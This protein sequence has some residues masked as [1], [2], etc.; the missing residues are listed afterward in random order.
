MPKNNDLKPKQFPM[1]IR[2]GEQPTTEF[3]N[4]LRAIKVSLVQ[5]PS[6]EDIKKYCI[7]F[8]NATWADN[9]F[10]VYNKMPE[11]KEDLFMHHIFSSK[12]LPTT[13][14][15]IRVNFLIEGISLQEVTH[16]LRYRRAVFSAECSGDKW[17]TH[18]PALV[19]TSIENTSP[20]YYR[21]KTLVEQ[22]KQLYVDMIDSRIIPFHDARTILPRCI[23]T[24]YYMS[25]SLKDALIFLFDRVDKQIQPMTDNVLAYR[26]LQELIA[27]YP[28][29]VKTLGVNFIEQPAKFY[30]QTARQ[31]RSTNFYKPDKDSDI[32]EWN[33]NDF[34]YGDRER[35][36][37]NGLD[38]E[39]D[40]FK[41]IFDETKS[42]II[43][44]N[45]TIDK[46]YG[47]DYFK[48]D[49]EDLPTF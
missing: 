36:E 14:E 48:Q 42:S 25:M 38:S 23:E 1:P 33:E 40:V 18:K 44:T 45:S 8:A 30:V 46:I 9:P 15:T 37:I 47:E 20:Y 16:I 24:Y 26:I 31:A 29:L 35:S 11:D 28:I 22:A 2:F 4:A 13:M 5:A 32:F 49:L 41:E 21:Y 3:K 39:R 10:D 43:A 34:V 27:Q 12:I 19:P 7:P 17:L 6:Y